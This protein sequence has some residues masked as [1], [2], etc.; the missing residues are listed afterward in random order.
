MVRAQGRLDDERLKGCITGNGFT[1]PTA[2][3][4]EGL[5]AALDYLPADQAVFRARVRRVAEDALVFLMKS[6]VSEGKYRGGMPYAM[7]RL[8]DDHP[9]QR[10]DYN[11]MQGEIRIDYVHHAISGMMLYDDVVLR[12]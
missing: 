1:C 4:V 11:K 12:K 10:R 3:R 9:W 7:F 5:V 8:P 2:S 6:Q